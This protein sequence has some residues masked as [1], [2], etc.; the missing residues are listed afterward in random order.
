MIVAPER[1][2]PGIKA[3]ACANPTLSASFQVMSSTCATRT[4]WLRRSAHRIT[5]APTMKASATGTGRNRCALIAVRER[6]AEHGR[7]HERDRKVEHE[8]ARRRVAAQA[9]KGMREAAPV[10]PDDGEDRAGLDHD[11]E[12][13]RLV[14]VEAD[15]VAREDQVPRARD[16]EEFGQTLDDAQDQGVDQRGLRHPRQRSESFWLAAVKR[17]IRMRMNALLNC[18]WQASLAA[19]SASALISSTSTDSRDRIVVLR[20]EVSPEK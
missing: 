15:Q 6:E 12:Y 3:K 2:V 8:A 18:T 9:A 1:E 17:S 10:L 5:R 16:G 20:S 14:A 11:L 19:S 13:L 7:G 4:R